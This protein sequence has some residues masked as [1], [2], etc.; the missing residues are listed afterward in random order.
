MSTIK[1][2]EDIGA[3]QKARKLS[4]QIFDISNEGLFSKDFKFRDQYRAA[5]GSIMDN[6]AEGFERGGKNEFK[7]FLRIAKGSAGE[8]KS[9]SYR[10]LDFGYVSNEQFNTLYNEADEIGK[11]LHGLIKYLKETD[12]RGIT[13]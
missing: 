1:R 3:W 4:H 13:Y 12:H 11:M 8:V 2:F 10:A 9:Q 7:N 5:S 6:I